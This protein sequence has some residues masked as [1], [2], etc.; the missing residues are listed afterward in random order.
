MNETTEPINGHAKPAAPESAH[1]WYLH[2]LDMPFPVELKPAPFNGP[3]P[4]PAIF[5]R[6]YCYLKPGSALAATPIPP[7][8]MLRVVFLSV[9]ESAPVR[10][11]FVLV[12]GIMPIGWPDDMKPQFFEAVVDPNTGNPWALWGAQ[13]G[14]PMGDSPAIGDDVP[15]PS[16]RPPL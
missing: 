2:T 15:S 7:T 12:P 4:G 11:E 16:E 5:Q 8:K 1:G 9:Y 3:I 13:D 10:R 14:V 6:A